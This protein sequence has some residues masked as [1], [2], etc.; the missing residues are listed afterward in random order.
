MKI[1][2]I[3]MNRIQGDKLKAFVDITLD[4]NIAV[5]GIKVFEGAK[6]LF[7][8]MPGRKT[9]KEDGKFLDTVH[10]I[11]KDL[12]ASIVQEVLN[13]YKKEGRE[14]VLE[15]G[16]DKTEI[17][18]ITMTK[19]K[20]ESKLKAWANISLSDSIVI[21]GVKVIEGK[22]GLFVVMPSKKAKDGKFRDI[23]HALNNETRNM[24]QKAVLD[25][26]NELNA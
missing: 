21:H 19:N 15:N 4:N 24:M 5:H 14:V 7:V 17:S 8:A 3:R 23:A 6:G 18:R 22:N 12:R 25:K 13:F 26:Y 20:N 16:A 9:K 11:N 1:T 10:I 2:T